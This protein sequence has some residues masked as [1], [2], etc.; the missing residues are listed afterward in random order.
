MDLLPLLDKMLPDMGIGV[1]DR[2]RWLDYYPGSKIDIGAKQ[3]RA[4]DPKEPLTD[5]IQHNRFI[6]DEVPEEFFGVSFTGLASPVE[7]DGEVIGAVAIQI[8][9]YNE[10]EL[11]RISDQIAAS[12]S[13]AHEQ[14]GF[15]L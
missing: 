10:R 15:A 7:A 12:L 6:K 13:N 2:T 3:G 8:Q 14:V 9:E 1:T 11:R 5:C 4:I